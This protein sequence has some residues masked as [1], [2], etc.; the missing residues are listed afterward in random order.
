MFYSFGIIGQ[1]TAWPIFCVIMT[2]ILNKRKVRKALPHEETNRLMKGAVILSIAGLFVKILSAAY[3]VPFQNI[4]GDVGFYIYQQVYPIFGIA[5]MLAVSGFP[6]VISKL[7]VQKKSKQYADLQAI[8]LTLMGLGISFS[9]LLFLGAG[10]IAGQMG[11]P[12]LKPLIQTIAFIFLLLPFSSMGRGYFQGKGQMVP[13]AISQMVEQFIRVLAILTFSFIAVKGG[14]SLYT[15]G[16]GA[17]A[18]SLVGSVASITCLFIFARKTN[19]K[20]LFTNQGLTWKHLKKTAK[21]MIIYGI[22]ICA[23][24][25]V[26]VIF[27]LIDSFSLYSLLVQS[28]ISE[29][30]A[31]ELKGVYDRG[32][33]L[34][35]LGAV[36]AASF[37]LVL[38]PLVTQ[39]WENGEHEEW[40][41]HTKTALKISALIGVG[42]AIGLVNIIRSANSMLFASTN[43]SLVLGVL[44]I[45]IIFCSFILICA[46]VLQGLGHVFTPVKYVCIGMIIKIILNYFLILHEGIL[47]AAISTV[48]ALGIVATCLII[49]VN[50][51][52]DVKDT[53]REIAIKLSFAAIWM[54]IV[55][56][57][58]NIIFLYLQETRMM[59]TIQTM[60]GVGIGAFIYLFVVVRKQLL[61]EEEMVYIPFGQR[62]FRLLEAKK[63]TRK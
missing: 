42:A 49:E 62:L 61:T 53:I 2:K 36:I 59:D 40:Q 63:R 1:A 39:A 57:L 12:L 10:I 28:G 47:G 22:A 7:V 60:V 23:S 4:V 6:V 27:Q 51:H 29:D 37:S 43:G 58:W 24:G 48:I 5:S 15:V 54:T 31:K 13:T 8:F 9:L 34:V 45:G 21:Q 38:V 41:Q 52:V 18:S 16:Q 55:L 46:A 33:P 32:Q 14:L 11:G 19:V 26:L 3:R 44:A 56:Q 35:Q 20:Q 30:M 25:L 50:K 17:L